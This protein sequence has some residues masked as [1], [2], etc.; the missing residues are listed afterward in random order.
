[1]VICKEFEV[2][3]SL[4]FATAL[5][6]SLCSPSLRHEPPTIPEPM[7]RNHWFPGHDWIPEVTISHTFLNQIVNS[8]AL[9]S[10]VARW[11]R[12]KDIGP[13]QTY[14]WLCESVERVI[15]TQQEDNNQEYLQRAHRQQQK[16]R[17]TRCSQ[18]C[19]YRELPRKLRREEV[20]K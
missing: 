3:S 9:A 1:M 17:S 16:L 5:K 12:L 20:N 14:Q 7:G 10:E 2:N 4:G 19:C 18:L 15:Q 6:T 8:K 13:D 11:R